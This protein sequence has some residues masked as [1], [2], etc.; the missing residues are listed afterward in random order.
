MPQKIIP[1]L[2]DD[3]QAANTRIVHGFGTFGKVY[4][5]ALPSGLIQR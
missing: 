5:G 2:E 4:R 1:Q 3:Q